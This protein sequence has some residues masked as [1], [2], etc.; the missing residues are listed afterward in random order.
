[1]LVLIDTNT[2]IGIDTND[3]W[4]NVLTLTEKRHGIANTSDITIVLYEFILV[5]Y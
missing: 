1:M 2:S 4:I 3:I 5:L